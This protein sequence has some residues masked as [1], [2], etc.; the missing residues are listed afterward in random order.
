MNRLA[1]VH[2]PSQPTQLYKTIYGG[3]AKPRRGSSHLGHIQDLSLIVHARTCT[4]TRTDTTEKKK[5]MHRKDSADEWFQSAHGYTR[6]THMHT[7][8]GGRQKLHGQ[9]RRS[10][11]R[12]RVAS[13]R[14]WTHKTYARTHMHTHADRKKK[15][16][17][18]SADAK[19]GG[20]MD[21]QD[22]RQKDTTTH[23]QKRHHLLCTKIDELH[24]SISV[25]HV[26]LMGYISKVQRQ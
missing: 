14:T 20:H 8:A 2:N 17:M 24:L 21:K 15:K 1:A 6:R 5:K 3:E 9:R 11:C 12:R 23:I 7:H 18:D 19:T 22:V 26:Q 25:C 16:K 4:H 13:A 10:E